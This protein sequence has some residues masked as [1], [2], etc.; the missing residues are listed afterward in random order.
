MMEGEIIQDIHLR[1]SAIANEI[2]TSWEVIPN[3]KAVKELL[4]FS[5]NSS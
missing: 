2:Y 3:E 1:F 4:S 5:P